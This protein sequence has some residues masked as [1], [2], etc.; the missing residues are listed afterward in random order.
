[1]FEERQEVLQGR[2]MLGERGMEICSFLQ[3][4]PIKN[5]ILGFGQ[6]RTRQSLGSQ[7]FSFSWRKRGNKQTNEKCKRISDRDEG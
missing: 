2:N 5:F 1:M 3:Q 4:R 6:Q 7:D